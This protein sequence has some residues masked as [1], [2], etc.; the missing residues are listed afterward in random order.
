[1]EHPCVV[2]SAIASLVRGGQVRPPELMNA[3]GCG[4]GSQTG[5]GLQLLDGERWY[6]AHTQPQREAIALTH[7]REQGFRGFLPRR[8]K[9]VRHARKV[10]T[11]LAPLFTRYVFVIL[12]L[13]R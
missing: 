4:A 6:V 11:V 12:N 13:D 9:N 2:K 8:L 1:M 3:I 7:L 5:S 10:Q